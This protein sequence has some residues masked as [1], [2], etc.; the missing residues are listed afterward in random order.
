MKKKIIF[1]NEWKE[2]ITEE[3]IV[4]YRELKLTDKK[5]SF[6]TGEKDKRV[7]ELKAVNLELEKS[8][9][10][11]KKINHLYFFISQINQ[12]IVRVKNEKVLFHNACRMALEFGKFKMAWIGIFDIANKKISL[13]N[14]SGILKKDARIFTD[15]PYKKNGPQDHVLRTGKYYICSDIQHDLGL[16]NWKSLSAK[17]G[18]RSLMI[19]PI[20]KSGNIIGTFN[21]YSSDLNF[22]LKEEV[23][24][25]VEAT[26]DISFAL[27]LFEKAKK[28][29][30]TDA[31]VRASELKYRSI[32]EQAADA[33]CIADMN[34]KVIDCNSSVCRMLGYS[35]EELLRLSFADIL[36]KQ[37]VAANPLQLNALKA[38]KTIH[39]E[40]VFKKKNGTEIEVETNVKMMKDGRVVVFGRDISERKK[41]ENQ[42]R[43]FATHLNH[44]V[45][46]ERAH[47]SREIHDELGQQLV[48]IKIGLSTLK[49]IDH[50]D[51]LLK[52]KKINGMMKDVDDTIQSLRKIATQ[53][54]PGILDTLG[55]IPSIR[56]LAKE[57]EKKTKINCL[58]D[59]SVKKDKFKKN[60]STCFFRICQEALTNISKHASASKVIIRVHQ[61]KNELKMI[62]SDNGKGIASK[63]LENSFSMG[64]LGMRERARIIGGDL[65]II[66]KKDSGTTIQLQ[67][68]LN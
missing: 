40:R 46:D 66:S 6:Q 1:Q 48:G 3:L 28:Q 52:G 25:L 61:N 56:W 16:E 54:R 55:L 23:A 37:D 21:L 60:I 30:E 27:D 31:A 68:P 34:M 36:T 4:A 41:S 62:V 18:I 12:N 63:K 42:I 51:T 13:V 22:S 57:Y 35:K 29:K 59:V 24:L 11:I 2:K 26:N 10:K 65:Q 45:E 67:A 15:L 53:L 20:K 43:N 7:T 5:L 8:K 38:G 49:K 32:I 33:I 64:L 9:E 17:H 44:V 39:N 19:L 50:A 47:L 14:Q 58:L